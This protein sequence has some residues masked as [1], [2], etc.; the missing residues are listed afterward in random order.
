MCGIA[1]IVGAVRGD[2]GERCARMLRELHHRGPDDSGTWAWDGQSGFGAT[3][4]HRRLS[5]IDLRA[6]AAQPMISPATGTVL[7]FNG[8]IY[9]FRELRAELEAVGA[10]FLSNGD[11][12]VIL[13]GYDHW[14]V[15]VFRRLRG[16][17]A[18]ALVDPV[19][20]EAILVRDGYGIKPLYWSI[21]TGADG[22]RSF[23]FA[24]ETRALVNAGLAARRT[25][26]VRIGRY[27]WNG[28]VPSPQ[29]IWTEVNEVPRGS[30]ARIGADT[31]TPCFERFWSI[32]ATFRNGQRIGE[33][34]AD[35][36]I[37]E[38][39]A[40]HLTADVP[41]VVFLSGGIDSTAVAAAASGAGGRLATM[42]I[43]FAE[44]AAD[45]SHFATAAARAI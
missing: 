18:A 21:W 4:V 8:E 36:E 43:G 25:D 16:M 45:E 27:L 15:D 6:I 30:F 31:V 39:V 41:K 40:A 17:F 29:T 23:A 35:R 22:R 10:R 9:N 3:L 7:V 1:G 24:S 11:S 42:S 28:F 12:E 33:V 26:P 38:C 14:G 34:E 44:A 19:R 20:G 13:N 5:I 2:D 37:A 32:G